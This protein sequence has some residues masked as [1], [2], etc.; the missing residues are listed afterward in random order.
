M[1]QYCQEIN[2]QIIDFNQKA[3]ENGFRSMAL[4]QEQTETLINGFFEQINWLPEEGR[5][6]ADDCFK[7]YKQSLQNYKSYLDDQYRKLMEIFQQTGSQR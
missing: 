4:F 3:F 6:I 1:H 2:R 5:R 7:V